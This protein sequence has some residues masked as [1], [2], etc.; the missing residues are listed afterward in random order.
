[1]TTETIESPTE[2]SNL[3]EVAAGL[4]EHAEAIRAI[5]AEDAEDER[6]TRADVEGYRREAEASLADRRRA[7]QAQIKTLTSAAEGLIAAQQ[8]FMAPF[9]SIFAPSRTSKPR[10]GTT[11][12]AAKGG[13]K[14]A[15]ILARERNAAMRKFLKERNLEGAD[16]PPFPPESVATFDREAGYQG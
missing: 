2:P 8:R 9:A 4:D 11:K 13:P 3:R 14:P 10:G 15:N 7:R 16:G 1:M 5:H 6:V 12:R